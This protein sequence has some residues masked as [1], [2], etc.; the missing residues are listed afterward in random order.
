M[1]R[2]SPSKLGRRAGRYFAIA[3][4]V[5]FAATPS[6]GEEEIRRRL[7]DVLSRREFNPKDDW[8]LWLLRQFAALVKWLE[9][10]HA[11]SPLLYWGVFVGCV[12]ILTLI[13]AHLAWTVRRL[14]WVSAGKA[15]DEAAAAKRTRLS[16][17]CWEEA[18]RRAAA[19]DFTEA[20]R[21]LFL[22]LVYRFDELGRVSFQ[23]AYTNREY[24]ALFADRPPVYTNL[25]VFVD[26]LDDNWYGQRPTERRRYEDCLNLYERLV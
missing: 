12:V 19:G 3:G 22:A 21:Y 14:L 16:Q 18:R 2:S 7:E 4:V 1:S 13:V 26:T 6:P 25:K 17:D 10:L 5:P 8:W 23:R 9:S 11:V 24:L 20:I 15:S